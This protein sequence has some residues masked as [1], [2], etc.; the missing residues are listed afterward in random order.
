MKRK[1][2]LLTLALPVF[3][4]SS[5]Q[6]QTMSRLVGVADYT[7]NG[8][9]LDVND[10]TAYTYSNGRGGDLMHTL[11]Y[12]VATNWV[13]VGDTAYNNNFYY[14]QSFDSSNNL[15][16]TITQ[17]WDGTTW[18]NWTNVVYSYNAGNQIATKTYQTWDGAAWLNQTQNVYG[19]NTAHQLYLDQNT[20]WD[21]TSMTFMPNT[22]QI[23]YFDSAGRVIQEVDQTYNSV[24]LVFDY[25]AQYMY[26]YSLITNTTTYSSWTGSGFAP[27]FMYTDKY[28]S[29]GN[30]LTH[31]YQTYSGIS[32]INQTLHVFSGFST[33]HMPTTEISQT[34]DTTGTG[35]WANVTKYTYAYNGFDQLTSSVAQSWHV[36]G[37][38]ETA[39][40]DRASSY[41]YETFTPESVKNVAS[42][43]GNANLY[44]VP[45]TSTL[46][47]DLNWNVAQAGTVAMYDM[48]GREVSKMEVPFGTQFSGA[49]SV[50]NLADGMYVVRITGTQAQMV[51]QIVV[52]H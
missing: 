18:V 32:W 41:Y 15:V 44:P 26:S 42:T 12:D 1:F 29:T 34:W 19:Y 27:N 37:F 2:L 25:T 39:P 17:Y 20:T 21:T 43:G 8:A 24:A 51:K 50:N 52:A 40:G 36:G 38:W 4:C 48:N 16:S 45:A 10:S 6:A 33:A 46:H 30:L 3:L 31:L 9:T 47:I 28:D 22:Q 14:I 11:K 35:S 23:Y 7:S 5:M 13:Y 49:L